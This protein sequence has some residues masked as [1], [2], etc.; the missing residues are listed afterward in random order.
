[1]NSLSS[2]RS[3]GTYQEVRPGV[4]IWVEGDPI[5]VDSVDQEIIVCTCR[6][7]DRSH[8]LYFGL[9]E[10]NQITRSDKETPL[11]ALAEAAPPRCRLSSSN[12]AAFAWVQQ[13]PSKVHI[14]SETVLEGTYMIALAPSH[15]AYTCVNNSNV[16]GKWLVYATD[17]EKWNWMITDFWLR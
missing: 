3:T 5:S 10:F 15:P 2:N 9:T 8:S 7:Y 11:D 17:C 13:Y 12:A 6:V 1:M 14:G 16:I 4:V